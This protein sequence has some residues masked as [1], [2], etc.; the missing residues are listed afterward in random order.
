MASKRDRIIEDNGRGSRRRIDTKYKYAEDAI[1]SISKSGSP[2]S[3]SVTSALSHSYSCSKD[4]D[5]P[6]CDS[7]P[8]LT[9][10]DDEE[11]YEYI[12]N[13]I[14]YG[15]LKRLKKFASVIDFNNLQSRVDHSS[16][17]W[18]STDEFSLPEYPYM[19]GKYHIDWDT[20]GID[21][22][23]V[24]CKM[25][26]ILYNNGYKLP[27]NIY[28]FENWKEFKTCI[29]NVENAK[30]TK[31]RNTINA[32]LKTGLNTGHRKYHGM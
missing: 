5:D 17:F 3:D 4:P 21:E 9:G 32:F 28:K 24:R 15:N 22:Q 27:E 25:Q 11:I 7:I 14:E 19:S 13:T 10:K 1:E 18:E 6:R 20:H 2:D 16:N 26:T 29:K 31:Q 8:D 30:K 23:I 12:T